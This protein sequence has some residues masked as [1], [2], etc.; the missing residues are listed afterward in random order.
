MKTK[1]G[2][3]LAAAALLAAPASADEAAMASDVRCVVAMSALVQNAQ[4]AQGAAAGLFYF[5]GRIEGR[6][7]AYDLG[8][9]IRRQVGRMGPSAI[10][11]EARRCGD[12][13][14]GRNEA[15]KAMGQTL[16]TRG[17]GG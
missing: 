15:L 17:V 13:V 4:Y 16:R 3:V 8:Q 1:L 2:L 9:A 12:Y 5:V 14:K 10:A 6:D 7:P 11:D